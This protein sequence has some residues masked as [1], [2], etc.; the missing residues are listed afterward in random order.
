LQLAAGFIAS[1]RAGAP[2]YGEPFGQERT[3]TKPNGASTEGKIT[4]P[5]R[6]RWIAG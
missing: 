5:R 6:G 3:M 1:T 2:Y 4:L